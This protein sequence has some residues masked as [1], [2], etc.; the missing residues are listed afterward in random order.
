MHP[1]LVRQLQHLG[2]STEA[3]PRDA[4]AWQALLEQVSESYESNERGRPVERSLSQTPVEAHSLGADLAKDA[5]ERRRAEE[6][7][8]ESEAAQRMLF[9]ASPVPVIVFEADTL[10]L[11][12]A[13]DAAVELYGYPRP[14]LLG[15]S[16]IDLC[17]PGERAVAGQSLRDAPTGEWR[18]AATHCRSD[19]SVFQVEIVARSLTL[20]GAAVRMAAVADVTIKVELEAQLRQSQKMEAVG[21]LAGGVAHDFNNILSVIL[22][23]ADLSVDELEPGASLHANLEEIR[24]AG[25]RASELTRQLLLFSR[26]Q[27]LDQRV[28][29]LNELLMESEP[30]L[31]GLVGDDIELVV[32]C[33]PTP[34]PVRADHANLEQV[35]ANL[36][37]NAREAMPTGGRVTIETR[38]VVLDAHYVSE[39]LGAVVGPHVRVTV[40]D[41]GIGMD[42]ATQARIFEPFFTTRERGRGMGLGLSTVFG[43][44]RQSGGSI[45]VQS[46][47]GRGTTFTVY[48]PRVD[49]EADEQRAP[50]FSPV[51][52]GTETILLVEDELQVRELAHAI[53][54]RSGYEVLTAG[55]GE[56]AL[57]ES[58]RYPGDIHLLLTDVVMPGISGPEL[59]RRL[60]QTRPRTAILCM[61][62]YTEEV[63]TQHGVPAVG[64]S[65]LQKP[66]TP[67]RLTRKVREALDAARSLV[68]IG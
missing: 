1:L 29:D 45:W 10:R 39:H 9:D 6:A 3:L 32:N 5:T 52:G 20:A 17:V 63:V 53:L 26:H 40:T 58:E 51:L 38:N 57:R 61:S 55:S 19:G 28:L 37:I 47:P 25:A 2:L 23:Y 42:K 54:R 13:N 15:L 35:F 34:G 44:V 31:A 30:T 59:A 36:V 46:D 18:G 11:V 48:L 21:R 27:M 49:A 7:L 62:G 12:G 16:V 4:P 24:T 8:R 65:Y 66:L 67:A 41:T 33:T 14:W 43:I 64:V 50:A 22:G 68:V 56:D 60:S